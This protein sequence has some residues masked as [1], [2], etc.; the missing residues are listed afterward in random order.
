MNTTGANHLSHD[1]LLSYLDGSLAAAERGA[2]RAHLDACAGCSLALASMK[3]FDALARSV[4]A[5]KAGENLVRSILVRVGITPR[6]SF[7]VRTVGALPY[8]FTMLVVGGVLLG[9]FAWTGAFSTTALSNAP[10]AAS[11]AYAAMESGLGAATQSFAGFVSRLVPEMSVS[12]L[13]LG[14]GLGLVLMA[15][16]GLDRVLASRVVQ[17]SR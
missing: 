5:E 3:E 8:V 4:P 13:R 16:A 12:G 17:R 10:G 6:Q 7:F 15:I 9:V 14:I 1:A 11:E 2:V